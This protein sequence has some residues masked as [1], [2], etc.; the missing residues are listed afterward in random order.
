MDVEGAELSS[1]PEWI[2]SGALEKVGD[3]YMT[4][5]AVLLFLQTGQTGHKNKKKNIESDLVVL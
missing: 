3:R 5:G 2:K 1:L 4:E